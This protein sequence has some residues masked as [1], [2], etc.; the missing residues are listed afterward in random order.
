M[1]F[2]RCEARPCWLLQPV[3]PP[4]TGVRGKASPFFG[5]TSWPVLLPLQACLP[6]PASASLNVLGGDSPHAMSEPGAGH[7]EGTW[8]ITV[9]DPGPWTLPRLCCHSEFGGS[10]LWPLP[11]TPPIAP[12]RL[13]GS[14][15][16]NRPQTLGASWWPELVVSLPAQ[17]HLSQNP[18]LDLGG[19]TRVAT[20]GDPLCSSVLALKSHVTNLNAPTQMWFL[21][22][23]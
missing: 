22:Y 21:Q 3:L 12:P 15:R 18:G 6:T 2:R 9:G 4:G 16:V 17:I 11:H 13:S 14:L 8:C 1:A 7:T 23:V 19:A 20:R 5:Q 10:E